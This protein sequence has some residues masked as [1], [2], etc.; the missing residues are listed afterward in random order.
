MAGTIQAA[1]VKVVGANGLI[2][3]GKQFAGRQVLIEEQEVGVW[4]IRTATVIPDNERWLHAPQ[5]AADLA[6]AMAW[7]Q[8]QPA[9]DSLQIDAVLEAATK[10]E[11]DDGG[12]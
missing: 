7:S 4:L 1:S 11:S 9:A 5:A 2:S 12:E 6:R 3:L 8:Q 10:D